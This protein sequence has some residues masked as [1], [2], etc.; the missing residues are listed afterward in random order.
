[1][2]SAR[3]QFTRQIHRN[4]FVFLYTS[5]EH[6]NTEINN[7]MPFTITQKNEILRCKSNK[8]FTR[9]VCW[10]LYNADEETKEDLKKWRDIPCSYIE[11]IFILKMSISPKLIQ[12]FNIIPTKTPARAF[13]DLDN[14]ILKFYGKAKELRKVKT[15]LKIIITTWEESGFYS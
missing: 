6:I 14:I 4:Q 5:N 2:S 9:L 3:F 7:I 11:R 10:K 12:R 8:T 15:I 1:M 13:V